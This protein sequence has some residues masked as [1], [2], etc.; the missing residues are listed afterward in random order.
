M[1][2]AGVMLNT[3]TAESKGQSINRSWKKAYYE[4]FQKRADRAYISRNS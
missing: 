4:N 2:F 1:L 3:G